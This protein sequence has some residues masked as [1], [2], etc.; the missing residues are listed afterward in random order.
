MA[1]KMS[2][3]P[4]ILE[5][6]TEE[7]GNIPNPDDIGLDRLTGEIVGETNISDNAEWDLES[8]MGSHEKAV[9]SEEV[10]KRGKQISRSMETDQDAIESRQQ[11][12]RYMMENDGLRE[13]LIEDGIPSAEVLEK[14]HHSEDSNRI[15]E[16]RVNALRK[17]TGFLQDLSSELDDPEAPEA[18]E[19]YAD[20]ID[21]FM[22]SERFQEFEE[23]LEDV[24]GPTETTFEIN[25]PMEYE[26]FDDNWETQGSAR[27]FSELQS[28]REGRIRD[29]RKDRHSYWSDFPYKSLVQDLIESVE[30]QTGFKARRWKSPINVEMIIDEEEE[31]VEAS[32]SVEKRS[33]KKWASDLMKRKDEV[34]TVETEVDVNYDDLDEFKLERAVEN[35]KADALSKE[36]LDKYTGSWNE[37]GALNE[38]RDSLAELKYVAAAA[39]Y[40]NR[41]EEKGAPVK[42][43][44][45]SEDGFTSIQ[46]LLEPNL[47][48]SEGWE[49]VVGNDVESSREDTVY[50]ITGPNNGGKTTYMNAVGLTQAMYQMGMPVLAEDAEMTPR[51]SVLTHYIQQEDIQRNQSR[52]ANELER[53]EEVFNQATGDSLV[54]I[55]EPFSG[56]APEEGAHQLDGTLRALG[57]LGATIYAS[58][59]YHSVDVPGEDATVPELVEEREGS[60]NLHAVTTGENGLGYTYQIKPGY[61][62]VSEGRAV[63]ED[64]GRDP[65]SLRTMLG[66]RDDVDFPAT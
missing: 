54:L 41:L 55:D 50:V 3:M 53:I 52:Y 64:L 14:N 56:T 20:E 51:D 17:Y 34:E 8:R 66:E 61:S 63:A 9:R 15:Y 62:T 30:K 32:A 23:I 5:G 16:R 58:T 45:T 18:V 39:E 35:A 10:A 49:E 28:G 21:A 31:T 38:V 24:E 37:T 27:I 19:Q 40:M 11:V 4:G 1:T 2:A 42:M 47:A 46:G 43:P 29:S 57:D 22:G 12:F 59:H 44:E 60:Q 25:L 7:Q 13:F 36:I 48:A 6:E 65:E 33:L 26:R